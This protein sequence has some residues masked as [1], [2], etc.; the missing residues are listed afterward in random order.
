MERIIMN[1]CASS[2]S[3]AAYSESC[4]GIYAA[5]DTVE[6]CK[7]DVET[8]IDLIK[9][10]LPEEQWPEQ[11][12]KDYILVWRYD[13]QS[14]LYY[15]GNMLSLSGLERLTGIHQKQLWAYMH[16]RSKPRVQQKERIEKALHGFAAELSEL[17]LV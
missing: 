15:Y 6:E 5:G 13:V 8:A 2:D 14:L 12:K 7:K 4:E 1:I 17:S 10:N 3:F 11:I 16:G 9:K